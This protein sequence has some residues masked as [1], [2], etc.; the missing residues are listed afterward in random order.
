MVAP[1]PS[2]IALTVLGCPAVEALDEGAP[3]SVASYLPGRCIAGVSVGDDVLTVQVR[4]AWSSSVAA[5]TQQ[6]RAVLLPLAG[7][8]RIDISVSD[9]ALPEP[10]DGPAAVSPAPA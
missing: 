4:M 3:G 1:D 9:I 8:R 7:G 5:L 2:L 6:V 10:A